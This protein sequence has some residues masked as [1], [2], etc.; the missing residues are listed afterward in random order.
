MSPLKVK[1]MMNK[2]PPMTD[3]GIKNTKRFTASQIAEQYVE[4]YKSLSEDV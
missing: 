4:L 3:K 1:R 2:T